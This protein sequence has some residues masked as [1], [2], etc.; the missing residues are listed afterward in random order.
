MKISIL[1][2]LND[3]KGYDTTNNNNGNYKDDPPRKFFIFVIDTLCRFGGSGSRFGRGSCR[4][5]FRHSQS[6]CDFITADS[7]GL[8]GG[9]SC[10]CT[11]FV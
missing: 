8:G 9:I 2:L 10:F 3:N 11:G 6:R 1:F 4:F 5:S 7:A